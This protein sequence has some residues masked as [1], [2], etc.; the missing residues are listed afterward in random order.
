MWSVVFLL[1]QCMHCFS[2]G[3]IVTVSH[4]SV[5]TWLQ[6][7]SVGNACIDI[8]QTLIRSNQTTLRCVLYP[9]WLDSRNKLL[10]LDPNPPVP[11]SC[12]SQTVPSVPG[13]MSSH[14][15]PCALP[16]KFPLLFLSRACSSFMF[17]HL[18]LNEFLVWSI[19]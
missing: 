6:L 5:K 10:S 2:N 7:S 4:Q 12:L 14:C 13:P 16:E 8:I 11:V 9:F 19:N 15:H 17:S 1:L 18:D 3:S